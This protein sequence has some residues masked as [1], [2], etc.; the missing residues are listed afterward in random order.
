MHSIALKI[1]NREYER[2]AYNVCIPTI[3]EEDVYLIEGIADSYKELKQQKGKHPKMEVFLEAI[4]DGE[5]L[6]SA[7]KSEGHKVFSELAKMEVDK[8][9]DT[10]ES[11]IR[12]YPSD[13]IL[14]KADYA[15]L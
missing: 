6:Q 10:M 5:V 4:S 7:N 11:L 15:L 2:I 13:E 8:I 3:S 9:I 14:Y 1:V 12:K